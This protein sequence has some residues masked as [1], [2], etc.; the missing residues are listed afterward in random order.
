MNISKTFPLDIF[1]HGIK[2]VIGSRDYLHAVAKKDGFIDF[3]A[4]AIGEHTFRMITFLLP[5]GDAMIYSENFD[6]ATDDD[7]VMRHE[8]LHA[9]SHILRSVGIEH[10]ADTEEVYAYA[11]EYCNKR[12]LTWLSCEFP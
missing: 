10:T 12:I 2:V 5:T 9:V 3:V 7:E 1:K 4:S 8:V 11:I 6:S